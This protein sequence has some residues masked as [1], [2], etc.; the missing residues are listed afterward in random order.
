MGIQETAAPGLFEDEEE[1][2]SDYVINFRPET[3]NED[4]E[5]ERKEK[6]GHVYDTFVEPVLGELDDEF[7]PEDVRSEIRPPYSER[8]IKAA[9]EYG[10]ENEGLEYVEGSDLSVKKI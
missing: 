5:R 2:E 6:A 10:V 3:S 7:S 1:D 4:A 9:L 8:E